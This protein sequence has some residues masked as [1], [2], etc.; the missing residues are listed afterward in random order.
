MAGVSVL[1]E[2]AVIASVSEPVRHRSKRGW[3]LVVSSLVFATAIV[4]LWP[5][6]FGGITG[7]TIVD[8][9]SMEPG[10]VTGDLVVSVRQPDYRVGEIVSYQVPEGQPG[11]G[12]RVIHRIVAAEG[13]G[14]D[15]VFTTKGDNNP[16]ID[17]W[18]FSAEDVLG[19]ALFHIPTVGIALKQI[20]QPIVVGLVSGLLVTLLLWRLGTAPKR[21]KHGMSGD[22]RG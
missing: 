21:G 2:S 12:G 22:D 20:S 16:S 8:G 7:L 13:T 5:A 1:P 19:K 3:S 9:T 17:P 18:Q 6:Q 10:Y 15:K 14:S 4:L 11:A